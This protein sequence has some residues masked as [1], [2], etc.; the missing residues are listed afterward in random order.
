MPYKNKDFIVIL[1]IGNEI[2]PLD[3]LGNVSGINLK[4][5]ISLYIHIL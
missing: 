2:Y 1:F 3:F 4:N 5:W